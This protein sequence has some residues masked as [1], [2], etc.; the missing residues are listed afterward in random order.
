MALFGST[1]KDRLQEKARSQADE[2]AR[3]VDALATL[4]GQATDTLAKITAANFVPADITT[5]TQFVADVGAV[6]ALAVS[7]LEQYRA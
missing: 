4:E 7:K 3:I 6:R 5:M 1:R 2:A